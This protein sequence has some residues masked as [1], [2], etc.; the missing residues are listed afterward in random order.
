[1]NSKWEGEVGCGLIGL[2]ENGDTLL[3]H[4]LFWPKD[5]I[6]EKKDLKGAR[7][8]DKTCTLEAIGVILPFLLIPRELKNQH[9]I[10]G[11]DCMGVVYGWENKK[12]K[13]DSCAS[14]IIKA[15]HIIETFLG[16]CIHVI[17]VPRVSNWESEVADN[18]SR[19]RTTGFL[20]KQLL[21]RSS[22]N[23]NLSALT[24]WLKNPAEDWTIVDRL[25]K[26]VIDK[27]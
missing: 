24:D 7:F 5:F 4:Q 20:E 3:T 18:L 22:K 13:G 19:E 15:L 1:M 11:V 2:H 14:M 9:I 16:S 17:H 21:N 27:S 12:V 25:V 26:H 6:T 10:C 8:G 23:T